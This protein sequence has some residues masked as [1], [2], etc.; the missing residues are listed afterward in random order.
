MSSNL[1]NV[2]ANNDHTSKDQKVNYESLL[3][4]EENLTQDCGLFC[5]EDDTIAKDNEFRLPKSLIKN[6]HPITVADESKYE[7]NPN[8]LRTYHPEINHYMKILLLDWMN[9]VSAEF[10]L[11]RE[12]FYLAYHYLNLYIDKVK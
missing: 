9:E 2:K 6:K 3:D 12:T 11:R 1:E 7:V 8:S 4:C 5:D 10:D